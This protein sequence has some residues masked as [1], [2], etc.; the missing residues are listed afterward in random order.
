MLPARAIVAAAALL[1][2]CLALAEPLA[3]EDTLASTSE[4]KRPQNVVSVGAGILL[5]V[6]GG[7]YERV[8]A[9]RLSLT[10]SADHRAGR[11]G[12]LNGDAAASIWGL[13]VGAH[14]FL[15]GEAP[16]GLWLGPEVGTLVYQGFVDG[17]S[18]LEF[19]PR[20]AFQ[21]GYTG[22][23]TDMLSVSVAGGVQMI[24]FVPAPNVR[25]SLGLAF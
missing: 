2:P 16:T 24:S 11:S 3:V 23:V 4:S 6:I 12:D 5:G 17:R 7:E 15:V 13:N 1:V 19:V 20:V 22:L 8:V 21:L 14:A 25:L 9:E 10:V 18:L